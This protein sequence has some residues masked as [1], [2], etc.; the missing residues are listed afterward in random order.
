MTEPDTRPVDEIADAF[1]ADYAAL[2]PLAATYF[3][4]PGHESE[5]TDLSPDGFAARRDLAAR[6]LA[7]MQD[8]EPTDDRG[9]AAKDA[10]VERQSVALEQYDAGTTT[11]QVSIVTSERTRSAACST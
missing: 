2:D 4:I 7:A 1:V 8:V 10:F 5:L 6:S 11:S 3:G 9:R